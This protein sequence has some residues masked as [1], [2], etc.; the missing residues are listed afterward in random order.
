[1]ENN[2]IDLKEFKAKLLELLQGK[3]HGFMNEILNFPLNPNLQDKVIHHFDTAFL[4]LRE[5]LLVAEVV[6]QPVAPQ[7]PA[8]P[9]KQN[10]NNAQEGLQPGQDVA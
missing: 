9:E 7:Q 2:A 4:W 8:E 5:A 3:Y 1:M 10:D 6:A